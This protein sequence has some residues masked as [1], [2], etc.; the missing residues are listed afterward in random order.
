MAK[1]PAMSFNRLRLSSLALAALL[2]LGH[3]IFENPLSY[4]RGKTFDFY[5]NLSP[6]PDVNTPIVLVVID[7]AALAKY[8]RWPWNRKIIAKVVEKS[9][10]AGAAVI[11]LDLFFPEA[12]TGPDGEE[13]DNAL[14][15]A[16]AQTRTVLAVSLGNEAV[17]KPVTPKTGIS[18]VGAVP[19]SLPG[20]SG[21]IASIPTL[22]Q[23]A[24][25]LG[26]IRSTPD[27]DSVLRQLPLI[28]LQSTGQGYQMWPS[29]ALELVRL[30]A[31]VE[32]LAVRLNANGF[33]ALKLG[34]TVLPMEPQGQVFLWERRGNIPK[35]SVVGLLEG[36]PLSSLKD[37]IVII[38][39]NAVGMDQFHT[40][41]TKTL[42]L[43][44]QI[45]ALIAEQLLF[46]A[47]LSKPTNALWIERLWFGI[48][49][50]AVILFSGLVFQRMWLAIPLVII[51]VSSPLVA[52]FLAYLWRHQLYESAQPAVGLFLVVTMEA[53][54]LYR[55]TEQ[56]RSVLAQQ[57]SQ[58]MSPAV[59][60]QLMAQQSEAGLTG[61]KRE[62]TVLLMDMRNFT[63]TTQNL[64]ADQMF[65]LIN[66]L[67]AIAIREIFARDGT[68]DKFMGDAVLAFWNA[69]VDQ[70]DHADRGLAA[71]EAIVEAVQEANPE[72]E[73]RGLP[74]LKIG[75]ALETGV[76]TVG[77]F[78]S[79]LRFDYTAIGPAMNAA[80][81][82]E[83][84]TKT[85]GVP[86][87]MGSGFAE[88]T[89]RRLHLVA[90]IPLKGF[91]GD[92]PVYTTTKYARTLQ[93]SRR[94]TEVMDQYTRVSKSP[95]K[96][97]SSTSKSSE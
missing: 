74:P 28:W 35:I 5:Q 6:R 70:S 8:G 96:A 93:S 44:S 66:H 51:I 76:C 3:I 87:V 85:V 39:N 11:G 73:A 34:S 89:S 92:V 38:S 18:I 91:E 24:S 82:L 58:F 53:Y 69:P 23:A 63:S 20:F 22:N 26:V 29:F 33:D 30:Y 17:A 84:A 42:R 48:A 27:S 14:A 32:S 52:G 40:T 68:I 15:V 46:N 97:T 55:A 57:F 77:N 80:A 16:L 21:V 65:D 62:I 81:R 2:L 37:A 61:E 25:G 7:D 71:A 90:K 83:A 43:G 64:N 56:R 9:H 45:H 47:F 54:S 13:G 78:G 19:Q 36:E 60:D 10:A 72:L 12:D 67:L 79:S 4:L 41:P 59:V 94:E 86:L 49:A 95:G 1:K 50:M 31:G 88:R 75:A